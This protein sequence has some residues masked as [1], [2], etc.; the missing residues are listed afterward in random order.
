MQEKIRKYSE[1]LISI[2]KSEFKIIARKF[3]EKRKIIFSPIK[4]NLRRVIWF[5]NDELKKNINP[6]ITSP[7]FVCSP[8]K[9]EILVSINYDG[10]YSGKSVNVPNK[11][12]F[13]DFN[14]YS[15]L[16]KQ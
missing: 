1:R 8:R 4:K 10:I 7:I 15:K 5:G 16:L 11:N 14:F 6:E 2:F 3:D 12:L 13:R 9:N